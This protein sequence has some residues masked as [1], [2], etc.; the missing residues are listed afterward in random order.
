M[1]RAGLIGLIALVSA[2]SGAFSAT[3]GAAGTAGTAGA[4]VVAPSPPPRASLQPI[5]CVRGSNRLDRAVA[6]T[7]VMRPVPGTWR[8]ELRFQLERRPSGATAFSQVYGGDLGRWRHP[9]NPATLGQRPGDVWRL[10]KEVVNLVAPAV[11]RFRVTFRWSGSAGQ[12]L[13]QVTR[14][15]GA[16]AQTQ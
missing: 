10:K 8:M 9:T 2:G 3:A 4:A 6:V 7:A 5:V 15:S 12:A 16:C 1:H 14:L 13:G 11:Y